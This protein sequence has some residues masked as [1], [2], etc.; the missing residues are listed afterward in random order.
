MGGCNSQNSTQISHIDK[1]STYM[2][3]EDKRPYSRKPSLIP[4]L[5]T[6]YDQKKKAL[7]RANVRKDQRENSDLD[8]SISDVIYDEE[9]DSFREE[10]TSHRPKASVLI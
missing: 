9:S 6:D 1:E 8:R 4:I 2:S 7:M 10:N 3:Q 5:K